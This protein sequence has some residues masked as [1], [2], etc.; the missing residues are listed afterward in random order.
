VWRRTNII[1]DGELKP[2]AATVF[3]R[4]QTPDESQE[5]ARNL[6]TFHRYW[7]EIVNRGD[8]SKHHEII[9]PDFAIYDAGGVT[10]E[11]RGIEI[12]E[13]MARQNDKAFSKIDIVEDNLI[14][15][16]NKIAT[17]WHGVAIHDKGPAYGYEAVPDAKELIWHGTAFYEFDE[18]GLIK[19][20]HLLTNMND[21]LRSRA[22]RAAKADGAESR[23]KAAVKRYVE[24]LVNNTSGDFSKAHEIISP[25]FT[26]YFGGEPAEQTGVDLFR[27]NLEGKKQIFSKLVLVEDEM[28]AEGNT[29]A[30]RWHD[31]A[32]HDRGDFLG[33][34]V[35]PGQES[36]RWHGMS[37]YRFD[38]NG[39]MTE[40]HIV[41]NN[42]FV[43]EMR[44]RGNRQKQAKKE[45][46]NKALVKR[47]LDELI[48][49]RD[50]SRALEVISPDFTVTENGR[51]HARKGIEF[52]K[53]REK[54]PGPLSKIRFTD[55][56]MTAKGN[57]VTVR[58]HATANYRGGDDNDPGTT[59]KR[60]KWHGMSL[61]KIENGLI[62]E[63]HVVHN[64]HEAI[65][66]IADEPYEN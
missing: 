9:S 55:D 27:D 61:Y 56:E 44:E 39:L 37:F 45:A 3:S 41:S 21:V 17:Q 2:D 26:A 66:Q 47:Y 30:V 43:L 10:D 58:W 51:E 63:G 64:A 34:Q 15:Q 13:E 36:M 20:A 49:G 22:E 33:Y 32:V 29:V 1:V 65:A 12:F 25:G 18:N 57:I 31:E 11:L 48:D 28:I 19:E 38:E 52:F 42:F 14:V 53:S 16:G 5:T 8:F 60:V 62:V 24:E 54:A 6:A 7:K 46:R 23:N 4:V 50:Y 59:S 35:V 40:G